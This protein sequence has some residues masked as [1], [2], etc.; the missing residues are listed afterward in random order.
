MSVVVV[1]LFV[2]FLGERG[3]LIVSTG[4]DAFAIEVDLC[5]ILILGPQTDAL[6]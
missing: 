1:S 5:A 4:L 2:W 3:V 6:R